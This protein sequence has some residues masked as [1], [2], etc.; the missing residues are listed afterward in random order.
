MLKIVNAALKATA[1]AWA[2]KRKAKTIR[3]KAKNIKFGLEVHRGQGLSL[4]QVQ[5]CNTQTCVQRTA[6]VQTLLTEYFCSQTDKHTI[7]Y[8]TMTRFQFAD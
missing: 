1:K 3:P 5:C 4:R 7:S 8:V 6:D 2:F